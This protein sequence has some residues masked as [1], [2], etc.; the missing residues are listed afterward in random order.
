M[1]A[2][3]LHLFTMLEKERADLLASIK[4]VRQE[5][6]RTAPKD[7]W[8][9]EQILAHIITG[10]R[11]S[12]QY[13]NKK[14][15]GIHEA[16]NSGIVEALKMVALTISQRLPFKFKAPRSV[17][18]NTLSYKNLDDLVS[19]WDSVRNELKVFLEKFEDDQINKKIY[20]HVRVG[21][22]NIQ[23]ALLFFREHLIHHAPQ[24]HRLVTH[25]DNVQKGM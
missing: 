10:E 12:I 24:I 15:L 20:R 18:E 7:K 14:I 25:K 2:R 19:D 1:N 17:V 8:S 11:L 13:L 5:H 9:I 16:E 21:L 4:H 22:L 6:F 23:Q 3:L